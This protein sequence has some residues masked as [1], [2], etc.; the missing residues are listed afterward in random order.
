MTPLQLIAA[1]APLDLRRGSKTLEFY[2]VERVRG[3]LENNLGASRKEVIH[4]LGL[5]HRVVA[6]A[7]R[8]IRGRQ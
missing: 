3:Y 7:I 6:K 8:I 1:S 2:N 4:A 5:D